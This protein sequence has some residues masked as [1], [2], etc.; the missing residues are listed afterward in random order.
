MRSPRSPRSDA[1]PVKLSRAERA[2][3]EDLTSQ[4]NCAARVLKRARILLLLHD[5]WAPVDVP[6]AAGAGEATVRRVRARYE[7]EGLEGALHDRPRPGPEPVITPRQRTHIVAMV[8][9]PPPRGRNRWTIRLVAEQAAKRNLVR[10]ISRETVRV[11]L[12]KH[13]LKPWR[14]KNVVRA[15]AG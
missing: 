13:E 12:N 4:G 10:E 6:S 9:G 2:R 14:K 7:R 5:G 15:G 1:H 8:C 3:L 11:L